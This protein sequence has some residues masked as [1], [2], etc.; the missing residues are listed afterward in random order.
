MP[1][2]L[3]RSR[4]VSNGSGFPRHETAFTLIELLAVIAIVGT[5]GA[6]LFPVLARAREAGRAT[7]C[8]A[9]EH[10][11]V[12][13]VL[14]YVQ[15]WDER[16]P[17]LHPTPVGGPVFVTPPPDAPLELLGSWRGMLATTISTPELFGC[18]SDIGFGQLHPSSYAPNGYLGYGAALADVSRPAQTI[19]A[20]EV[21]GGSLAE[22][23]SPWLG[24]ETLSGDIA[25][26]RHNGLA[27]YV[28]VD[29]HVRKLPF[30]RTWAPINHYMLPP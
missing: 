30:D 14:A 7:A 2:P 16:F 18:P 24:R 10:Q 27:Q 4:F 19:L 20:A 12:V 17:Q 28:F 1:I 15:D 11:I 13:G 8:L 3:R 26:D 25:V 22:D 29:G 6:I 23:L 9:H 21:A 5:L